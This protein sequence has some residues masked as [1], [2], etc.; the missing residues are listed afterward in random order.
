MKQIFWTSFKC[1]WT[2]MFLTTTTTKKSH[3]D[4]HW[5]RIWVY[6]SQIPTFFFYFWIYFSQVLNFPQNSQVLSHNSDFF[7]TI[8]SFLSFLIWVYILQILNFFYRILK[9]YPTILTDFSQSL[10]LANSEFFHNSQFISHKFT[11]FSSEF[12]GFYLKRLQYISKLWLF[13][14]FWV[15]I[16]Q[17]IFFLRILSFF[18]KRLIFFF[19]I[20]SLS[21][22]LNFIFSEFSGFC[23]KRL[24]F[25]LSI[26]SLYLKIHI[27]FPLRIL[28]FYLKCLT[29]F[30]SQFWVYISNSAFF[31]KSGFVSCRFRL[32]RTSEFA[33]CN[34][35]SFSRGSAYSP[36]V[37]L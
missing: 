20:L 9:L 8:L 17:I 36:N 26:F 18:L 22:K 27:L 35:V 21:N 7:L 6:I 5:E 24:T 12:S 32:S 11:F 25:F 1:S 34:F 14:Q 30:L 15:Y 2:F 3:R 37:A 19:R 28:R 33:C 23:L 13:S 29:F 4:S 10:Y 16:S 31:Q